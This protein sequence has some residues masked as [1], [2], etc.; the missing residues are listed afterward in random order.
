MITERVLRVANMTN[1]Q[2]FAETVGQPNPDVRV[3]AWGDENGRSHGFMISIQRH[4]LVSG[5]PSK[6]THPVEK[7][8]RR[9]P[10]KL[11]AC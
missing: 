10:C 11:M 5:K 6:G 9:R 3:T 4:R 7:P 1:D 2:S 8:E